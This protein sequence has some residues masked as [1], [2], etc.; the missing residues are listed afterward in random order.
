M[1][2]YHIVSSKGAAIV[3]NK[4]PSECSHQLCF[5]FK[6]SPMQINQD[7][8]PSLDLHCGVC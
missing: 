8:A 3:G 5:A 1:K 4:P 7:T 6:D 2:K